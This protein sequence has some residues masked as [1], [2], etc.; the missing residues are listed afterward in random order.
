MLDALRPGVQTNFV[1]AYRTSLRSNDDA[2]AIR[3]IFQ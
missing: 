2:A 3:A 1:V